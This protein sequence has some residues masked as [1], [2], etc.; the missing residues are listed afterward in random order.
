M[1]LPNRHGSSN[2]YRYGFQGQEK[3]D[4]IKGEGNSYT[5]HFRQLDVRINR[6]LSVDP[7]TRE[8]PW[9]SPYVSMDNNPIW[10]NDVLGD[11]IKPTGSKEDKKAYLD[12]LNKGQEGVTYK[13]S[14]DNFRGNIIIDTDKTTVNPEDYNTFTKTMVGAISQ[15][16]KVKHKLIRG[17]FKYKGSKIDAPFDS[18]VTGKVDLND[19]ENSDEGFMLSTIAHYTVERAT[20]RWYNLTRTL[21]TPNYFESRHDYGIRIETMV[22]AEYYGISYN[23][24]EFHSYRTI[25]S[26]V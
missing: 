6:W 5:T 16:Q 14:K 22:L 17:E 18:Y 10:N 12:M 11:K 15:R 23:D 4:E 20:T 25:E 8:M 1:S 2:E 7:R 9:Q 24:I 13:Y 26:C 19:L 21:R 3:D